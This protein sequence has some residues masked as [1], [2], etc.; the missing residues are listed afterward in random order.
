MLVNFDRNIQYDLDNI[1]RAIR[2]EILRLKPD[3][4]VI[5]EFK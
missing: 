2:D 3:I 5:W 1:L 4:K